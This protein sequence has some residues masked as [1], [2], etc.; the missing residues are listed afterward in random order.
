L[1]AA[2]YGDAA[3]LDDIAKAELLYAYLRRKRFEARMLASEIG[4]L[5]AAPKKQP[6]SL[7]QLNM[8]GFGIYGAQTS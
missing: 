7:A 5:F 4:Q 1:S 3:W 2:V 6:M 8:M